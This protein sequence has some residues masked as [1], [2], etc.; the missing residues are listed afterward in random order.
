MNISVWPCL[1][2]PNKLLKLDVY[3]AM[4]CRTGDIEGNMHKLKSAL[5]TLNNKFYSDQRA[6]LNK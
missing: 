4:Q 1:S 2:R 5:F 6:F 3:C